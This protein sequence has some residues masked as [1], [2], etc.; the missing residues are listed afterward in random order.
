MRLHVAYINMS[1]TIFV[2][3]YKYGELPG[4]ILVKDLVLS[5]L[6]LKFDP[7]PG[8]SACSRHGQNNIENFSLRVTVIITYHLVAR[9]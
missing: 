7:W 9:F 1:L 3:F 5:L 2:G 8:T 6:W 4:G